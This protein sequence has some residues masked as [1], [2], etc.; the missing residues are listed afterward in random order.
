MRMLA[1]VTP[2]CCSISG[3]CVPSVKGGEIRTVLIDLQAPPFSLLTLRYAVH[4]VFTSFLPVPVRPDRLLSSDITPQS[5]SKSNLSGNKGKNFV[6]FLRTKRVKTSIRE[7]VLLCRTEQSPSREALTNRAQWAATIEQQRSTGCT[8]RGMDI[9]QPP[10][11]RTRIV[12]TMAWTG[13]LSK[14]SVP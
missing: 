10:G 7:V 3:R 14:R 6:R 2:V 13:C 12:I 4:A 1:I 8:V 11:R 9:A 5:D